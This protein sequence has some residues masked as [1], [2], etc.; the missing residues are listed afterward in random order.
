MNLLVKVLT[1]ASHL[2]YNTTRF[3]S[4]SDKAKPFERGG[5]KVAGLNYGAKTAELPK[6]NLRW[7]RPYFFVSGIIGAAIVYIVIH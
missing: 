4:S 6:D 2:G 3:S 5:R 1:I 7:V